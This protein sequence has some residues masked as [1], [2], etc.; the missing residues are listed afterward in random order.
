MLFVDSKKFFS[1]LQL[2]L[3]RFQDAYI[4]NYQMKVDMGIS[5][6]RLSDKWHIQDES[7]EH[8][9]LQIFFVHL[10]YKSWKQK[11]CKK[12]I[13]QKSLPLHVIDCALLKI[14][15]VFKFFFRYIIL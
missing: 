6:W 1:V 5:V 10:K 8:E 4:L 11:I 14:R 15:H 7:S 2:F 13:L 12:T 9:H 3:C